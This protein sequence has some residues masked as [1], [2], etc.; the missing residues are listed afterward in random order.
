MPVARRRRLAE[1]P[2]AGY[3]M[4]HLWLP[5][6]GIKGSPR[7]APPRVGI[8]AKHTATTAVFRVPSWGVPRNFSDTELADIV[9]AADGHLGIEPAAQGGTAAVT[10]AGGS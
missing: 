6:V 8:S 9:A 7:D 5:V 2:P 1:R 3:V 10:L 4:V